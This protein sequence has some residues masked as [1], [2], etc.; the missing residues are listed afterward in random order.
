MTAVTPESTRSLVIVN[1]TT[2]VLALALKW[3][4]GQ[5]LWPY[6][7]QS[8]IIGYYS[9]KRILALNAAAPNDAPVESD[10][11]RPTRKDTVFAATFFTI[12]YGVAHF[13]YA[14]LMAKHT[15]EL[16]RWDWLG[17]AAL[18]A[19]F[20]YNH[21]LSFKQNIAADAT[22]T[23]NMLKLMFTPYLRIVP[24]HLTNVVGGAI[25]GGFDPWT[26]IAFTLLKTAADVWM[27]RVEHHV[28]QQRSGIGGAKPSAQ[29]P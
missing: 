15:Y 27:H 16:D 29:Q 23:P 20:A 4:L 3:P 1:L 10:S 25:E 13:L 19:A 28:L 12:Q 24:M 9:C 22:G 7:I 6:W 17:F 11:D 8:M 18:G 5:L 21:R 2:L 14:G 26:V